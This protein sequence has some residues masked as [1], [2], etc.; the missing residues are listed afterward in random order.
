[1]PNQL[2]WQMEGSRWKGLEMEGPAAWWER[3]RHRYGTVH[4]QIVHGP[5]SGLFAM[6]ISQMFLDS[7]PS[8]WSWKGLRDEC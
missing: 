2:G 3:R 7:C 1:M 4:A 8:G 6:H 5:P